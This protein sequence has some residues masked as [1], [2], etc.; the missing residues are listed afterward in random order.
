MIHPVIYQHKSA[1]EALCQRYNV[2][3]LY[4]FGS[5]TTDAFNEKS[6]DADFLVEFRSGLR[7]EEIGLQLILLETALEELLN[8][9]VD[10]SIYKTFRNPYFSRSVE[11]SKQV[12]YGARHS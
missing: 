6:S 11:A 10:L 8:R 2:Q 1:L 12:L 4:V 9:K 3:T 5:A 7:P